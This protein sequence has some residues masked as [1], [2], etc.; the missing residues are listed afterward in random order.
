DPV[1]KDTYRNYKR[2]T[3]KVSYQ[4]AKDG[5]DRSAERKHVP[6]PYWLK[7]RQQ[8]LKDPNEPDWHDTLP[9]IYREVYQQDLNWV[10]DDQS[11]FDASDADLLAQITQGFDV[12]PEMVMKLIELETS[13]EGLSRRQG[14]F[15]KLGTI[16]K[17]DWGS[18]AEIQ[19]QQATLQKRNDRDF[20]Q[21]EVE[22]LEAELQTLQRRIID[23]GESSVLID[24]E[25]ER[26][27]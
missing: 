10:V 17:Q 20:H 6:G 16:L 9:G 19:Q 24:E 23:A 7:Y 5:E 1:N 2:R 25:N 13:M 3:G 21:D 15:D 22:K 26:A 11:R 4:Y 14:I 18:L 27:H 8:W 12:V